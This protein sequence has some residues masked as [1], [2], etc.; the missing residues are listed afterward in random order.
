M[1]IMPKSC[2]L[3]IPKT[4]GTWVAHV[5]RE[6]GIPHEEF[7][8]EGDTHRGLKECPHPERFKFA[9][10]R[11]PVAAYQSYW[12]YK[13]GTDW[14]PPNQM[15]REC[16]SEDFTT[17]VRN[18]LERYPGF[19]THVFEQYVG[20]PDNPIEFIGKQENLVEDLIKALKLAGEKFDESI[21]RTFPPQNVSDRIRF[22]ATYT[23]ELER[24]VREAE[25]AAI[26]RYG[27]E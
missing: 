22:D 5:I 15:D 23:P 10:V 6:A 8:V 16:R 25:R 1:I 26:N 20:P 12:R 17:F 2:F 19:C 3:H 21:I 18:V 24:R 7:S 27:Y 11:H 14:D 9:F 13:I 4:G